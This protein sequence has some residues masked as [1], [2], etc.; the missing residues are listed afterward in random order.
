[1]FVSCLILGLTGF[2]GRIPAIL[3]PPNRGSDGNSAA[4]FERLPQLCLVGALVTLKHRLG[5]LP[6]TKLA[7]HLEGLVHEVGGE[8]PPQRVPAFTALGFQTR[9]LLGSCSARHRTTGTSRS[10][11]RE[12]PSP[13]SGPCTLVV[14]VCTK[15]VRSDGDRSGS[16]QMAPVPASTSN[17]AVPRPGAARFAAARLRSPR[18]AARLAAARLRSPRLA[19]RRASARLR[20]ARIAA[21]VPSRTARTTSTRPPSTASPTRSYSSFTLSAALR[22]AARPR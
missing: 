5:R 16:N 10:W 21:A 22:R 7:E 1:M 11:D 12:T 3:F 8:L 4:A 13:G 18:S 15:F 14:G 9:E 6:A 19:A 2:G 20:P 17:G